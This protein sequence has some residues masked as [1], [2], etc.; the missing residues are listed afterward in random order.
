MARTRKH[1]RNFRLQSQKSSLLQTVF[2]LRPSHL[3]PAMIIFVFLCISRKIVNKTGH[4]LWNI[5]KCLFKAVQTDTKL[6]DITPIT[7]LLLWSYFPLFNSVCSSKTWRRTLEK[8]RNLAQLWRLTTVMRYNLIDFLI[9]LRSWCTLILWIV[10]TLI[11][12]P[13]VAS[14]A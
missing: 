9:S 8:S 5:K 6:G 13:C 12:H 4:F 3:Q 1:W 10:T 14:R 11:F 7:L 2:H